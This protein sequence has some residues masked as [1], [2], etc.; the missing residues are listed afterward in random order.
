MGTLPVAALNFHHL[1]YFWLAA[2]EGSVSRAAALLR[3]SQPTATEQIR[4]LERELGEKLFRK[5]GRT[6]ALTESGA[7]VLRYADDIFALGGELIDHVQGR[8]SGKGGRL[9]V[10]VVDAV[11]KSVA[12]RLLAPALRV[13]P[14]V[15]LLCQEGSAELLLDSLA[16]HAVDLV[17]AD[18]PLAH[19]LALPVY[20]N[21]LA[22]VP[23]AV[24][25][26]PA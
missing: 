9:T 6:L 5:A 18:A 12:R 1:R 10:G 11:P 24:F 16:S 23:V 7:A 8:P 3:V 21:L 14:R 22:E 26:T 4:M 13:K 25:G 20:D 17:L 2:R 19:G 15:R